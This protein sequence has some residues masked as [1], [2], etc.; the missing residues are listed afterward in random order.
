MAVKTAKEG[1]PQKEVGDL[2]QVKL[3]M[4]TECTAMNGSAKPFLSLENGCP[5]PIIVAGSAAGSST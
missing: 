4:N 5:L 2:L 1:A 3:H